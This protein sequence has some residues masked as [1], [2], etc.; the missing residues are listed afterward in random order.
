MGKASRRARKN[1]E[2]SAPK[3]VPAPYV[4]RPFE[5]LPS[6]TDWVAMREIVPAATGTVRL[7]ADFAD[8]A[9][10]AGLEVPA[11][12]PERLTVTTA[13]PAGWLGLHR[14]DGERF[15]ALQSVPTR[16]DV[17]RDLALVVLA[18]LAGNPG[19][20]VTTVATPTMDTPRLQHLLDV[21][22]PFDAQVHEG[23]D[24]WIAPDVTLE[25]DARDSLREANEAII[26]TVKL[27]STD[28]AYWCRVGERTH[29]RWVL[30]DDE[31][32]ATAALARLHA[33]GTLAGTDGLGQNT[34]FLGAFR[35][36][37]VL[38]PVWDTDPEFDA[39]AYEQP[40]ADLAQRYAAALGVTEPLN[41][42]ERRARAGLLSRQLTL[43]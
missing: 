28:S 22:T 18:L 20:P 34:R 37:G 10:G 6:E 13:L 15:V 16:G 29:I 23:F 24:Y 3:A 30:P 42:Q 35:A 36:D 27:A 11:E 43:R 21:D 25:A 32:A 40:M 33:A 8:W 38:A 17:S 5:G 19:E 12:L 39:Q 2:Q 31:D 41:P 9:Q 14:G 1:A 4:A 26:P 7:R